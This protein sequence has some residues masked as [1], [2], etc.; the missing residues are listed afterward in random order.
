MQLTNLI[1]SN[2]YS[3]YDCAKMGFVV[4]VSFNK[5]LNKLENLFVANDEEDAILTLN[6]K[7]IYK[8]NKNTILIRNNTKL[9]I[10]PQSPQSLINQTLVNIDGFEDVVNNVNNIK[11]AGLL[12]IHF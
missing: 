4:A 9:A 11:E 3:V 2:V 5:H 7:N 10:T 1:G 8:T 12:S 6:V